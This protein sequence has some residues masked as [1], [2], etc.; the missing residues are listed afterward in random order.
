M[1]FSREGI[2]GRVARS[3][4]AQPWCGHVRIVVELPAGWLPSD[5]GNHALMRFQLA[6]VWLLEEVSN[7]V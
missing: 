4:A 2:V 7:R 3:F 6:T 5:R 1:S